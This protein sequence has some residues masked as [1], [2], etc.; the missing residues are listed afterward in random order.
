MTDNP[1]SISPAEWRAL[2]LELIKNLDKKIDKNYDLQNEDRKIDRQELQ[3]VRREI[4]EVHIAQSEM[5]TQ[6]I[7]KMLCNDN[8]QRV[9]IATIKA[10]GVSEG[11]TEG[12]KLGGAIIG[13]LT[14]VGF[15]I[16]KIFGL[17]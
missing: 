14:A 11:K 3:E 5:K 8:E 13:I 2:I 12:T 16:A 17:L 7:E 9:D 10:E 4:H 1:D 6:L 15:V